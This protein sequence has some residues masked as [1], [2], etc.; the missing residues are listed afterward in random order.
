MVGMFF[1]WVLVMILLLLWVSIVVSFLMWG[2]IR[3]VILR[4][5][6]VCW[7]AVICCQGSWKVRLVVVKG[8]VSL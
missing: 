2:S 6:V 7:V 5:S 1:V 8:C 3:S 4:S